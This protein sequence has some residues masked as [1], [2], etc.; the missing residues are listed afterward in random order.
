MVLKLDILNTTNNSYIDIQSS[1]TDSNL[2]K[3]KE[4]LGFS[5]S[6]LEKTNKYGYLVPGLNFYNQTYNKILRYNLDFSINEDSDLL[7]IPKLNNEVLN[8]SSGFSYNDYGYIVPFTKYLNDKK[9]FHSYFFRFK[10]YSSWN[11]PSYKIIPTENFNSSFDLNNKKISFISL[12]NIQYTTLLNNIVGLESYDSGNN[13]LFNN[14]KFTINLD[15]GFLFYGVTYSKVIIHSN[16][17]I[18]FSE[19]PTEPSIYILDSH[20]QTPKISFM[21]GQL[22]TNTKTE[23]YYEFSHKRF[24]KHG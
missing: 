3:M 11:L 8:F 5:C 13:F 7:E 9:E 20:L 21:F 1:Y 4:G 18:T 22:I 19:F 14:N 17:Y 24:I 16:G 15:E 10:L 6:F 12:D 23:L 2:L